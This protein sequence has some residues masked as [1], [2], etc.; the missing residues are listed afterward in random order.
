M[1]LL[2]R[3]M[4]WIPALGY[5]GF[6]MSGGRNVDSLGQI[7]TLVVLGALSGFLFAL[8]FTIRQYRRLTR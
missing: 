2:L 4:L 5:A 1:Y 8:L 6:L 3:M 7:V